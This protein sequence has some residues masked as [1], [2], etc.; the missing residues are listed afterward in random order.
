M[1]LSIP[2]WSVS[3]GHLYLKFF[4]YI[5]KLPP[6]WFYI[7]F[8][9]FLEYNTLQHLLIIFW[10]FEIIWT[11]RYLEIWVGVLWLFEQKTSF[12]A[13]TMETIIII[14]YFFYL[15]IVW[16][17]FYK[18]KVALSPLIVF[19]TK[20]FFKFFWSN[21]GEKLKVTS[22]NFRWRHKKKKFPGPYK[23]YI[24]SSNM[25]QY[26]KSYR[27][28]AF[29]PHPPPGTEVYPKTPAWLGLIT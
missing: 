6:L 5:L 23:V 10:K 13:V 19:R 25:T 22:H 14:F 16:T 20:F 29:L 26:F 4:R 11:N 1:N 2:F 17:Q 9:F 18:Y 28:R 7:L 24:V 12:S 15:L 27:G 3:I 8:I 21:L